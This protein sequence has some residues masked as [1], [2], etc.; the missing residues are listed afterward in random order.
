[1][2]CHRLLTVSVTVQEDVYL[3]MDLEQRSQ[4]TV[5]RDSGAL[6][7]GSVRCRQMMGERIVSSH[8]VE[9]LVK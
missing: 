3:G 9:M 8:S 7:G 4:R 6:R 5:S 2:S 1:M